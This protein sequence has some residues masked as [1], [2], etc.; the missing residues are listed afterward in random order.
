MTFPMDIGAMIFSGMALQDFRMRELREALLQE[1]ERRE[2]MPDPWNRQGKGPMEQIADRIG[3]EMVLSENE[4][5]ENEAAA[6]KSFGKGTL[7]AP[8]GLK[9]EGELTGGV[10]N[11]KGLLTLPDGSLVEGTFRNGQMEEMVFLLWMTVGAS[12]L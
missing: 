1:V 12:S 5:Y 6:G 8:N 2:P 3:R 4:G 11:G 9:Y 10:P 7:E